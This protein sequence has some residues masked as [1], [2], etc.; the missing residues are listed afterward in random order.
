[1]KKLVL[2]FLL[3]LLFSGCDSKKDRCVEYC[4]ENVRNY[5][6]RFDESLGDFEPLTMNCGEDGYECI[7]YSVTDLNGSTSHHALCILKTD[8]CSDTSRICVDGK[9]SY[10]TQN[11][12]DAYAIVPD[13]Y[14]CNETEEC[15]ELYSTTYCF[16]PIDDCDTEAVS[17]CVGDNVSVCYEIND[18]FYVFHDDICTD[19]EC[20]Y[21]PETKSAHCLSDEE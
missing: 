18:K 17:I 11:N 7:E 20:I 14:E 3:P 9:P 10:C 13:G 15:V 21:D 2:I 12:G 4:D 1:M 8:R 16:V 5:C 6:G 19:S